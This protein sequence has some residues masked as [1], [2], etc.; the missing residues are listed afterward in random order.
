MRR[1][2]I[3]RM[4]L[5]AIA[6]LFAAASPAHADWAI[7]RNGQSLHISGYERQGSL[8]ILYLPG[9][10]TRL[11]AGDI[12]RIEP[13]DVF[14]SPVQSSAQASEPFGNL[15]VKAARK[16][17]LSPV[18]LSS[19]IHA[20][21]NFQPHAVSPKGALGLMQLMPVTARSLAVRDPFDPSENVRGG[22]FYLKQLLGTFGNLN[23]ALAAYNAGPAAVR[24]YGGVPPFPETHAYIERVRGGMKSHPAPIH[25]A[26]DTVKL[27][28]SPLE[29]RC[30]AQAVTGAHASAAGLP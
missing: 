19:V 16:N 12:L 28:C 29:L 4:F 5:V 18:L 14:P 21:S 1:K 7:L 15:V 13:E 22:A 24:F 25:S 27:T 2:A 3:S 11:P 23:L 26:T 9:G 10:E 8:C 20:E 30:R 6:A 17:G